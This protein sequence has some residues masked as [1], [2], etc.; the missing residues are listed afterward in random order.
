MCMFG[1]W[2]YKKIVKEPASQSIF[3]KHSLD[4]VFYNVRDRP[5]A[6]LPRRSNPLPSWITCVGNVL[7]GIPFFTGQADFVC[8]NHNDVV[9]TV[10]VRRKAR[11]MLASDHAGYLTCQTAQSLRFRIYK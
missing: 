8:I 2:V 7:L 4:S 10:Y 11:L 6:D 9:T 3:R 1:A 5:R